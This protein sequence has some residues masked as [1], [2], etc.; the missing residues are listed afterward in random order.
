[1]EWKFDCRFFRGD[2]PCRYKRICAESDKEEC[3]QYKPRGK[4]ILIIKLAAIGDVLRTTPV[5]S[6]LKKKYPQSHLTWLS[7]EK[8]SPPGE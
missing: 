7:E 8:T 4:K 6:A 1:M 3:P 2:K 5:L